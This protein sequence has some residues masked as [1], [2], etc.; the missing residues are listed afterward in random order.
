[1]TMI[2]LFNIGFTKKTAE[3][4]FWDIKSEQNRLSR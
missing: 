1:M 3:Q 4:F 2:K